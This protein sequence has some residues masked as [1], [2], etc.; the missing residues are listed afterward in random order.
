[1]TLH[2]VNERTRRPCEIRGRQ[3]PILVVRNIV[4]VTHGIVVLVS[5]H[6]VAMGVQAMEMVHNGVSLHFMA[7]WVFRDGRHHQLQGFR[8]GLEMHSAFVG[9]S[10]AMRYLEDAREGISK[11]SV[12][13]VN[14]SIFFVN[15]F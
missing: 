11:V 3:K 2:L 7:N 5:G 6:D 4:E 15:V 12:N 8:V 14:N 10:V 1:M 9:G 13:Q